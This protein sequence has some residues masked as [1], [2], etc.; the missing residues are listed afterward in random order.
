MC[1]KDKAKAT[2][3]LGGALTLPD[4][5]LGRLALVGRSQDFGADA[6]PASAGQAGTRDTHASGQRLPVIRALYLFLYCCPFTLRSQGKLVSKLSQLDWAI[7]GRRVFRSRYAASE[8]RV[9]VTL[10]RPDATSTF[11]PAHR[12]R[13]FEQNATAMRELR[14][15]GLVR[16]NFMEGAARTRPRC[17]LPML[18]TSLEHEVQCSCQTAFARPDS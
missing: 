17:V 16:G 1:I 4:V 12:E 5:L 11:M 10:Y 9:Q 15:V 6:L 3:V 7:E 18:Q 14:Q 8:A 13:L 2:G